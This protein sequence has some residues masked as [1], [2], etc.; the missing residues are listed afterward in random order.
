MINI[1]NSNRVFIEVVGCYDDC[2]KW[3]MINS[4]EPEQPTEEDIKDIE[5]AKHE[6]GISL[7]E[8][9]KQRGD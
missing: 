2:L 8:Y 9:K 1:E 5:R 7:E 6:D 4:R 3:R